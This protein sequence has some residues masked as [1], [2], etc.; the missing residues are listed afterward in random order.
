SHFQGSTEWH[1]SITPSARRE[2]SSARSPSAA[3]V[4]I[5]E[6]LASADIQIGG[7]RPWDI[8]V[9]DKRF[10][11]YVLSYG[12]LAAGESYMDGWWDVES[13]DELC[14]RVHR[15]KIAAKIGDWKTILLALKGRV[16][17]RQKRS[18]ADEVAKEHY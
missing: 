12:S 9:H 7:N 2:S 11:E 10:Y 14:A 8:Q 13:L 6:L 1:Y 4:R 16:F 5:A 18:K 15:A 17:N 3:R